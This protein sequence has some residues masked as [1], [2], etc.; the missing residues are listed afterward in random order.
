MT[1]AI[2]VLYTGLEEP[3]GIAIDGHGAI[4]VTNRSTAADGELLRIVP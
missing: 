4:Y 3:G 2:T 1:K